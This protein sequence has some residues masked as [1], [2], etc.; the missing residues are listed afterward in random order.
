MNPL[1]S[2]RK[3]R[4]LVTIIRLLIECFTFSVLLIT[5]C[6]YLINQ[7]GTSDQRGVV[8]TRAN[9]YF[10]FSTW[11]QTTVRAF[12]SATITHTEATFSFRCFKSRDRVQKLSWILDP[13]QALWIRVGIDLKK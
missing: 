8:R 6:E 7:A 10:L 5:L 12:L 3:N 2:R 1:S 9:P 13:E 4:I 11:V